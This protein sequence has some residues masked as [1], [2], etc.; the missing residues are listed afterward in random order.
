MNAL[1]RRAAHSR[2]ERGRPRPRL[3]AVPKINWRTR[4]SALLHELALVR[5]PELQLVAR[6]RPFRHCR[7]NLLRRE[8]CRTTFWK[9]RTCLFR[10]SSGQSVCE[11]SGQHILHHVPIYIRQPKSTALVEVRQTFVIDAKELK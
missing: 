6:D 2:Q 1:Q 5:A 9:Y 11:F 7:V 10:Q 3:A 8:L 4:A